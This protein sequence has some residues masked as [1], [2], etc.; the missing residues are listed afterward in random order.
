MATRKTSPPVVHSKLT[1]VQMQKGIARLKR[2]ITEIENFDTTTLE[3]RWGPEQQA[4]EAT[5]E[6]TLSSVFG[7]R[8]I[9]YNRYADATK[10]DNGPVQMIYTTMDARYTAREAREYVGEGKIL[11][12]RLLTS[13]TKWLQ[14]EVDD[15][16]ESEP[17]VAN[18]IHVAPTSKKIFIVH[19]H[20][21]AAL[22]S[23]ARFIERIGLEAIILSEQ[24]NQGKT[25]IE[26]IEA[27]SNVGFAVVLLTPDD[28]G[29][30]TVADLHPRARQNVLLELGYFMC[31]LGRS[32][33]CTLKKG[34]IDIPTDFAGIVWQNMDDGG[35]WKQT[36]A[37][38]LATTG[39]YQID[40]NIVMA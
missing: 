34:N 17:S 39:K 10:L 36:L 16:T 26:K 37:R 2:L 30:K 28:V 19:G 38:E 24:A 40:W 32:N 7:H 12:I 21:D 3:E 5:I 22:Q 13:A 6:A 33:V 15:E 9:E 31:R 27:N 4:L 8:T 35:S 11:A 25:I 20:D 14:D 29:G 23:V 1:I 18:S